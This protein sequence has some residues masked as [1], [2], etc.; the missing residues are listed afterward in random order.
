MAPKYTSSKTERYHHGDLRK[1]LIEAALQELEETGPEGFSL[2]KVAR[3]AGVSH[4]AP[5]HHFNDVTGLLTALAAE[6]FRRFSAAMEARQ[7]QET[8]PEGR[9]TAAGLGYLDFAQDQPALFRL[10]HSSQKPDQTNAELEEA[11]SA[12]FF[13]LVDLV[14][15]V[16]GE[17]PEAPE[18]WENVTAVWAM[19]H[20]IA[21][22]VGSG[23]LK[24]ISNLPL[25]AREK[26][27]RRVL[28]RSLAPKRGG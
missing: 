22:L 23:R 9:L 18:T 5:A 10:I 3:R 14:T 11:S 4:A 28:S 6:G 1:A 7:A 26:A 15:D 13:G 25:D 19:A 16:T 17:D 27:V 20:G 2:R 24:Y 21:D 12:S 8:T